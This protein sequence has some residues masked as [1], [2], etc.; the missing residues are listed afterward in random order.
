MGLRAWVSLT[1][2]PF[3]CLSSEFRSYCISIV[4]QVNA[5]TPAHGRINVGDAILAIGGY[6]ASNLT[7]AQA[8]QMIKSA[9][10]SL[11]L[12]LQK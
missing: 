7:H 1:F 8:S 11:E 4:A 2:R 9:G 5:G 6:D 10:T 12:T 3:K